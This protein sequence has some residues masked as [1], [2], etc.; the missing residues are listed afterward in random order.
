MVAKHMYF[1]AFSLCCGLWVKMNDPCIVSFTKQEPFCIMNIIALQLED[2]SLVP[3][4]P[5]YS[6]LCDY[7]PFVLQAGVSQESFLRLLP[8]IYMFPQ[9]KTQSWEH[10]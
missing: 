10:S 6:W 4:K 1:L 3:Q 5:A 7:I 2:L 8:L 9:D